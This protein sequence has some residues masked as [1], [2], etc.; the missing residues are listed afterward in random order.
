MDIKPSV[1]TVAELSWLSEVDEAGPRLTQL[2]PIGVRHFV[3]RSGPAMIHPE[4]HPYCELGIHS[5]GSGIEFVE[6]EKAVRRAGDLFIAGPGVPHW[7]EAAR[8]PLV[9]TAIYFLPSVLCEFGPNQDGLHI[10]RRFTARQSLRERLVRPTTAL[11][12]RILAGFTSISREFE[13]KAL[14][15]EIRLRTLLLD[16]LVELVRW[17]QRSGKELT[18]VA[19]SSKWQEVNRALQYLREHFAQPVYAHEVAKA[20][21]ISESRLKVLFRE[22]LGM[23]WSRYV[24]GYRIQQAVALLST[25]GCNV[26]QASLAVGFESLS[27]FNATFRAFM[28]MS[29]SEYLKQQ[30]K[31]AK[32]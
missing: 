28:G 6:R 10:L 1:S 30:P 18:G 11:R 24:Q 29:P 15:H 14:G 32:L 8:Y 13:G 17:E 19:H 22:A 12:K 16:M 2:S 26:T 27:H 20:V 5:S 9:G 25:S 7:F 3:V 21:G 23:P 31:T 4:R